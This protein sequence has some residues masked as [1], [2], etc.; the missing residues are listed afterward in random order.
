[1]KANDKL[2]IAQIARHL[3][4]SEQTVKSW[5]LWFERTGGK[6]GKELPIAERVVRGSRSFRVY[7]KNDLKK[8]EKFKNNKIDRWG[9]MAK[10][11]AERSWGAYGKDLLEREKRGLKYARKNKRTKES[12]DA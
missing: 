12:R 10:F 5:V 4:V 6:T 9:L 8:F 3:G 2:S 11:N 1:M 7:S